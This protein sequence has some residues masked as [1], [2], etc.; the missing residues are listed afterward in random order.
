VIVQKEKKVEN[1]L[2]TLM[3]GEGRAIVEDSFENIQE[4]DNNKEEEV[5][6]I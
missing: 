6:S 5:S 1:S 3:K 4:Q 2:K